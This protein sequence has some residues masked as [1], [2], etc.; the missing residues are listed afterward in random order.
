MKSIYAEQEA[1]GRT[2][3]G[4]AES[5]SIGKGVNK[6]VFCDRI[7]SIYII[8]Y[9]VIR[10]AGKPRRTRRAIVV[11][12]EGCPG[13]RPYTVFKTEKTKVIFADEMGELV[14]DGYKV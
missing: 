6:G 3:Y 8:E 9:I 13:S 4:D 7:C 14:L 1:N 5:F 11:R 2:E 10:E 12:T